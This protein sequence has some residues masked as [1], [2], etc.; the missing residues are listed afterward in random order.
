MVARQPAGLVSRRQ[1]GRLAKS[2]GKPWSYRRQG[3]LESN[4]QAIQCAKA[5][6]RQVVKSARSSRRL[7]GEEPRLA[8]SLGNKASS[9]LGVKVPHSEVGQPPA[10]GG[11]GAGGGK[12]RGA[13]FDGSNIDQGAKAPGS[14][15]TN[16]STSLKIKA[17]SR[18]ENWKTCRHGI[19]KTHKP[20]RQAKLERR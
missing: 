10:R 18:H 13:P 12:G 3:A 17:N 16:K 1:D 5:S 6:R 11:R 14:Q 20:R 8:A 4:H 9:G 2:I 15:I 19:T 7:A